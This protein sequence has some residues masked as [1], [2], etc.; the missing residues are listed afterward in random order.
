MHVPRGFTFIECLIALAAVAVLL[1][2]A[3]HGYGAARA[4]V[5]AGQAE[6]SLQQV[7]RSAIR[8]SAI[9]ARHVVVCSSKEGRRCDGSTAWESGWIAFIDRDRN[10]QPD[11]GAALLHRQ[12]GFP[13]DLRVRSTRG[14]TRV[15]LQPYGGAAA[16]SNATF[17]ICD[18]R[19]AA[20]ARTVVMAASGRVRK[21]EP[22]PSAPVACP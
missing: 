16:G 18:R 13:D 10:G 21:S 2:L 5:L 15:V 4:A 7:L 6:A 19:G 20:H 8:A 3:V 11:S 22:A 12:P 17:T 14:R 1:A 9:D